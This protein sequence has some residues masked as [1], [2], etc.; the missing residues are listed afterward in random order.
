VPERILLMSEIVQCK[1]SFKMKDSRGTPW[2]DAKCGVRP[3]RF[4]TKRLS[5]WSRQTCR[6]DASVRMIWQCCPSVAVVR[7]KS[8]RR[9]RPK[10]RCRTR[11]DCPP[12]RGSLF[13]SSVMV[14]VG[15]TV[16]RIGSSRR[17]SERARRQMR[18]PIRAAI[19]GDSSLKRCAAD[20][21]CA[22]RGDSYSIAASSGIHKSR[23]RAPSLE[24]FSYSARAGSGTATR[25]RGDLGRCRSVG[26]V[27]EEQPGW[28]GA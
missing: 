9:N 8:R 13:S 19:R 28:F 17:F 16:E 6:D 3:A 11:P 10:N 24:H 27:Q 4:R 1:V 23:M 12:S 15:E 2:R 20:S 5:G 21:D 26:T 25:L 22:A 7:L 18:S 14:A